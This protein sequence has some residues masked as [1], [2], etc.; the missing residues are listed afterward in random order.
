[1]TTELTE[2]RQILEMLSDGVI[3]PA[4][5]ER[6]LAKLAESRGEEGAVRVSRVASPGSRELQLRVISRTEDGDDI[7]VAIPLQLLATGIDFEKLLPEVARDAIEETGIE[8]S[9]LSNLR[10]DTLIAAIRSLEVEVAG[11]DG[12][13]LSIH[14]E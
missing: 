12:A 7:D 11:H 4:D 14:C 8:L 9:E 2:Q 6:L 13:S 3:E 1:M 10:G 5:A